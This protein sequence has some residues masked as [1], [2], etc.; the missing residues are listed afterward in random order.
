M[1]V[2]P[3]WIYILHFYLGPVLGIP[4]CPRMMP[5]SHLT[6]LSP[7]NCVIFRRQGSIVA[8]QRGTTELQ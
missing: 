4:S 3:F 2:K 5:L 1:F 8:Q 6:V 7:L